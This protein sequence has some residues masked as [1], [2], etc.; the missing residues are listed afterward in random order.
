MSGSSSKLPTAL[1][2]S[3]CSADIPLREGDKG[4][5]ASNLK[6]TKL[7]PRKSGLLCAIISNNIF[8]CK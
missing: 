7:P 5:T 4:A 6:L 3:A 1:P 2:L 8:F